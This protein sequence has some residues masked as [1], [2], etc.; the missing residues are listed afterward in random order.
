MERNG[1]MGRLAKFV[2]GSAA[3]VMIAA[4]V[5]I[6]LGRAAF[7]RRVANE[8]SALLAAAGTPEPAIVTEADVARL[9]DPV[10]RWLRWSGVVGQPVP[11]SVRLTQEGRFRMGEG[12]S[13]TPFTAE[14][15]FT[16]D[17]PG[18][19]W[20]TEM[21]MA[22]WVSVVG[23]DRY[24]DGA[25]SIEMRLLGLVPVADASGPDLDRGAL[26]RYLNETLWFPAAAV[27]RA[28][29]WEP[30]DPASARAT[31]S[32]AGVSAAAVFVFDEHG[33]PLDMRA[34]RYD[35]GRGAVAP[36]STP[37]TAWGEFGGVWVPIAGRALWRYPDGDFPY[38]ELRITDIAYEPPTR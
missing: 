26:L 35:M 5:V 18:F 29:T 22:P 10:G 19:L 27:T 24:A 9:P 3:V 25:G 38:V 7:D 20:Y 4:A 2:L 23:R 28:I 17:P 14:E 36:W 11:R 34:D 12:R 31:I 6:A 1:V 13:W 21:T 33:R 15:V 16:T 30:I 8:R 37:L 32:H